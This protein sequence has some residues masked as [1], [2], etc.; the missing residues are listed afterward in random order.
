[1]IEEI[2]SGLMLTLAFLITYLFT[3]VWI[4]AAKKFGLV[5]KDLNKYDRPLVAEGGGIAFVFALTTSLY[6]YL[7]LKAVLES[8][9]HLAEIYALISAVVLA[10]L[11]GFG[12][13]VPGWKKGI[14][15]RY[16]P[17]ITTVLA[18]PFMTVTLLHPEYNY[19]ASRGIPLVVFSFLIVPIGIIGTSNAINM[20][21][22]YK[23]LEAGISAII[24]S[25]LGIR[26]IML[27]EEWIGFMAF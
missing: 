20:M 7:F 15:R 10:G 22:G 3:K 16:K 5:G 1:M 19:F 4:P 12:D 26:A 13:D 21:G 11:I 18:L 6:A 14:R 24:L 27:G 8:V 2:L 17:F 25:A 9:T 23:G